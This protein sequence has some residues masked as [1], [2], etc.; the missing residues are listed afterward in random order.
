MT[1][2]NRWKRHL[3]DLTEKLGEEAFPLEAL[4][5]SDRAR[6]AIA[7]A[8]RPGFL[9]ARRSVRASASTASAILRGGTFTNNVSPVN[10]GARS[11]RLVVAS[12][13]IASFRTTQRW[14][15]YYPVWVGLATISCTVSL[16][17]C[18]VMAGI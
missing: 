5:R 16:D 9:I 17:S 15:C 10:S 13:V 2:F 14:Q 7:T 8:S 18:M 1:C 3:Q 6:V 12:V 4:S 11:C